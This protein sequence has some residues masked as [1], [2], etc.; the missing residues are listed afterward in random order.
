MFYR[1]YVDDCFL[2]FQSKEQ[3]IPFLDYL[4][5]K[6][7]NI[8]F[9]HE[10]ENNGSLSFLDINITRTNGRFSTSV[11]H[12]PTSTGLCTNINSFIPMTYKKG[13]L[14]SL[15]SRYFNICSSYQSF[16]CELQNFK[17]IFSLNGY[18]TSLIDNC[19]S[20]FLDKIFSPK[21]LVH[22]CSKKILFFCIPYTG[23]HGLQIRTQLYKLLSKAYP[24]I[25]IRFV[26][27]PTCRLSDFFPF[28]DRIPFAIRSHV[29]YKYKCQCCGAL[30]VGQTR[31]HIHS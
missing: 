3:V 28:K 12:K 31:R 27:R 8:Q 30:Y 29:V 22:F 5:S 11:F 4:N 21:P 17:Q 14:L 15:I 13:L 24:H 7:P 25:S 10:L 23:Q 16:H 1:R 6:L 20:T 2:I 18:P 9:T 26:F 19:I